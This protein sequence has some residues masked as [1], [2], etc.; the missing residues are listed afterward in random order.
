MTQTHIPGPVC[1]RDFVID[2]CKPEGCERPTLSCRNRLVKRSFL[3]HE[4][5]PTNTSEHLLFLTCCCGAKGCRPGPGRAASLEVKMHPL[6]CPSALVPL[7]PQDSPEA[8]QTRPSDGFKRPGAKEIHIH[9]NS[10]SCS[11]LPAAGPLLM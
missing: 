5:L 10:G 7:E 3:R 9:I 6:S 1:R 2:S 4:S 8:A 11:D